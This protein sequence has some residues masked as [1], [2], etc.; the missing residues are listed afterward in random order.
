MNSKTNKESIWF[1]IISLTPAKATGSND[2]IKEQFRT[3]R[4]QI[5]QYAEKFVG[6]K[7]INFRKKP[8]ISYKKAQQQLMKSS[9]S[10]SKRLSSNFDRL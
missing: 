1:I 2:E 7:R 4:N 3:V 10:L 8:G 5:R 6:V 9:A